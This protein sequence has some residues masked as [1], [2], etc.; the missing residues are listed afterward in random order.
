MNLEK[1]KQSQLND[2]S[3]GPFHSMSYNSTF[4]TEKVLRRL[5]FLEIDKSNEVLYKTLNYVEACLD[6][7]IIIPDRVEK[8]IQWD[9]FI[10]LMFSS[11]L[12]IFDFPS[13]KKDLIKE[14]WAN[15][16]TQSITNFGFD[17]DLY[18]DNYQKTF[19]KLQGKR[20][21]DPTNFYVVTLVKD[22][23]PIDKSSLYFDYILEKGIYYIY[24]DSLLIR[25]NDFNSN[26]TM[27]Y[28][29]ALKLAA[30]YKKDSLFLKEIEKWILSYRSQD[31]YWRLNKINTDGILFPQSGS[32]RSKINKLNDLKKY[33]ESILN[34]IRS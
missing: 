32:W 33:L 21:L 29:Y 8:V 19:G 16:I 5:M 23:L 24:S 4:T 18:K 11:W 10:D 26:K 25:P 6:R 27:Y 22:I 3:F 31:G 17:Y 20:V 30:T 12:T 14:K 13:E 15:L 9:N 1:I 28:L 7:K 34:S 2:G